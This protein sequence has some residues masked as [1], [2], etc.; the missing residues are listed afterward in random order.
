MSCRGY[1]QLFYNC[2]EISGVRAKSER[3]KRYFLILLSFLLQERGKWNINLVQTFIHCLNNI[4]RCV[5]ISCVS[6]SIKDL[7]FPCLQIS[8][9]FYR[10]QILQ[11][12]WSHTNVN[13][14]V[15]KIYSWQFEKNFLS[16]TSVSQICLS[17][18][19]NI[20]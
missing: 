12:Y 4:L 5:F 16:F 14:Y 7:I 8:V 3:R 2:D 10:G 6:L 11:I 20:Y 19:L 18:I 13:K 15:R 1:F 17:I 9:L